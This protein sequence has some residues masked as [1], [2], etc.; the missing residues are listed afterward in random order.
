MD[1]GVSECA[2]H[3]AGHDLTEGEFAIVWKEILQSR[4]PST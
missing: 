2:D 4:R 3:G 1:A